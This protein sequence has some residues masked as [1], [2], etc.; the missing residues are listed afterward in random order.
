MTRVVFGLANPVITQRVVRAAPSMVVRRAL[1]V[2]TLDVN[3]MGRDPLAGLQKGR[4]AGTAKEFSTPSNLPR[5]RMVC[6][7]RQRDGRRVGAVA[8]DPDTGAYAFDGIDPR[9]Q[10]FVVAFDQ[11]LNYNAV[12]RSDV[13][14]EVIA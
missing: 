6:L 13:T 2:I 1:A 12:I 11:T 3:R 9:E 4:I 7:H 5:R 14:P 10:Y 8:S